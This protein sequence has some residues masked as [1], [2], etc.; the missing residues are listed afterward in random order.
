MVM[1]TDEYLSE[2]PSNVIVNVD[3]L[4]KDDGKFSSVQVGVLGETLSFFKQFKSLSDLM[5]GFRYDAI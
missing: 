5:F 4:N 3:L 1:A 2:M